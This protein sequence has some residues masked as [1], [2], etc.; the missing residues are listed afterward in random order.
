M[1]ESKHFLC[2]R[3]LPEPG[4]SLLD[5]QDGGVFP[6]LLG[7]GC[8]LTWNSRPQR[9][10]NSNVPALMSLLF[11][12]S[13]GKASC[14][15]P[16]GEAP[17]LPALIPSF[18]VELLLFFCLFLFFGGSTDPRSGRGK[19]PRGIRASTSW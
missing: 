13:S 8:C 11:P 7:G 18:A 14:F 17:L 19:V 6:V 1:L 9:G 4:T 16:H 3:P 2:Q 10:E 5:E 15:S 12:H